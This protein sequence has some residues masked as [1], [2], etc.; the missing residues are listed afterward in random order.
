MTK[1]LEKV[2]GE[3]LAVAEHAGL[4]V[5]ELPAAMED[6]K[7]RSGL[8]ILHGRPILFLD[9]S[10]SAQNRLELIASA[11]RGSN[12]EDVYLSPAARSWL[13]AAQ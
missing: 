13:E 9:A 2:A 12:L 6:P 10:L 1:D 4:V 8:V 3:L 11:L 7:P 5:R